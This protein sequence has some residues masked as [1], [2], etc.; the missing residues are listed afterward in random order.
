MPQQQRPTYSDLP[1]QLRFSI[2][3]W[4]GARVTAASAIPGGFSPGLIAKLDISDGR[5]VF[6]KS[7]PE[8]VNNE[9]AYLYRS[10]ITICRSLPVH[11]P[12]P[13]LKYGPWPQLLW[14]DDS[15]GW[16]TMIFEYVDGRP[17]RIPWQPDELRRVV[18]AIESFATAM[19]PTA[20]PMRNITE[21]YGDRFTGWRELAR[22]PAGDR[23]LAQLDPWARDRVEEL[24]ELEAD[25]AGGQHGSLLHGDLRSDNLLL[26]DEQVV[27]V[28]WPWACTGPAWYDLMMMLPSV[29]L[30]RGPCPQEV[31]DRSVLAKD[32]DQAEVTSVLAALTGFFVRQS[33]LPAPSG[34]T[35]LREFQARQGE[36]ALEWLRTRLTR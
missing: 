4:L 31:F 18:S 19:T 27:M 20:G 12:R 16:V 1:Q 30:E 29:R 25:W 7:L 14:S 2:D 32:A 24:A 13:G 5:R 6:I 8:K 21:V 35:A 10:E 33:L 36:V 23:Q 17:P 28:D 26:T 34:I 11:A 3:E 9:A 22:L 15:G